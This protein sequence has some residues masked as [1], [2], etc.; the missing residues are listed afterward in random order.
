MQSNALFPIKQVR[1]LDLLERTTESTA[2][3]PLKSK[4][5]LMSP[6]ECEVAL[7]SANQLE[8]K[9]DS[10]ALALEQFSVPHHTRQAA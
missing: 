9:I 6:Q 8:I 10:T 4:R 1:S 2:E 3:I 7:G 5:T